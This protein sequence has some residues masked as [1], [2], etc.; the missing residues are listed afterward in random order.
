MEYNLLQ[1][2]PSELLEIILEYI[3]IEDII[4]LST[5]KLI[6]ISHDL[7]NKLYKLYNI[8]INH[9]LIRTSVSLMCTSMGPN[10]SSDL[11]LK[12]TT[13]NKFIKAS[14]KLNIF[15]LERSKNSGREFTAKCSINYIS[16]WCTWNHIKDHI[17]S[18]INTNNPNLKNVENTEYLINMVDYGQ[19]GSM[20]FIYDGDRRLASAE[21]PSIY[22]YVDDILLK[23][24]FDGKEVR[25]DGTC[26]IIKRDPLGI[27]W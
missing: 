20:V 2:I 24:L 4:S 7:I 19:Y 22:E 3:D 13:L 23:V 27:Y 17:L 10:N 26:K 5:I 1:Q 8:D 18:I 21:V 11:L 9:R 12:L 14:D 6:V 15:R 16:S 25:S